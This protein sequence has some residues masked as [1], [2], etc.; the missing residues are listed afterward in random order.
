MHSFE[1]GSVD[2]LFLLLL[3]HFFEK[4]LSLIE[5]RMTIEEDG[6]VMCEDEGVI[7]PVEI[8]FWECV[9]VN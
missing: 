9:L 1:L 8:S 7:N 5:G 6:E 3:P 4:L 2:I